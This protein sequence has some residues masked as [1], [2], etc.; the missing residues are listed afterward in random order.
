LVFQSAEAFDL[1]RRALDELPPHQRQ[2]VLLRDVEDVT[3]TEICNIL[4]SAI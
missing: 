1:I 2:A 3:P 4:G